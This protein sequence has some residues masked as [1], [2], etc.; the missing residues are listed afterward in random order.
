MT[1][2]DAVARCHRHEVIQVYRDKA[3]LHCGFAEDVRKC[4]V[5]MGDDTVDV[6]CVGG[7]VYEVVGFDGRHSD[8]QL[9]RI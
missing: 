9:E 7:N 3:L 8:Y 6:V 2:L 1:L 4:A 5:T